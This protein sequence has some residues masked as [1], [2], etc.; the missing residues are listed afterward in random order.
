MSAFD[1]DSFAPPPTR[2]SLGG[3]EYTVTGDPDVDVVARM[4]RVEEKIGGAGSDA[5]TIAALEEG[6]DILLQLIHD[7]DP[8]VT[9]LKIG[10]KQL[11]VVFSLIVHGETVA[12]AVQTVL[13]QPVTVAEHED[14]EAGEAQP[15]QQLDD[16]AGEGGGPLPS[17]R[18]SSERSSSS[19]GSPAGALVT[20]TA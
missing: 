1:L 18:R 19:D 8:D 20:G 2:F 11:L 3:R 16:A 7:R 12:A 14:G 17:E 6:R 15:G 10:V 9:S 5:E 13:T 4:L